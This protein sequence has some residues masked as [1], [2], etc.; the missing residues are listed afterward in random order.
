MQNFVPEL[1]VTI[2]H[3]DWYSLTLLKRVELSGSQIE[4][5][6]KNEVS[7]SNR[8]NVLRYFRAHLTKRAADLGG[9]AHKGDPCIYCGVAHD[10]VSVGD[11]PSR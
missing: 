9:R 11:C 4:T 3:P 8:K 1:N 6:L 2:A 10:D 5:L 7:T